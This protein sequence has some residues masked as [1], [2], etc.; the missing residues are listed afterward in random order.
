V[1]RR[2]FWP[3]TLFICAL[4]LSAVAVFVNHGPALSWFVGI[5]VGISVSNLLMAAHR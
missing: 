2:M 5:S 4:I 3:V 1:P